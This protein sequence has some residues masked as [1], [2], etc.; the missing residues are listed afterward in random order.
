MTAGRK[1]G[2]DKEKALKAAMLVFWEKGYAGASLADLT[3]SM[4]INKPSLYA[5]FGNKEQLHRRALELYSEHYGRPNLSILLDDSLPVRGRLE[6]FLESVA[7]TQFDQDLPGGCLVSSC[8]SETASGTLP[9]DTVDEVK[10]MRVMT[11]NT[12]IECFDKA[13][14]SGELNKDFD[15]KI[16]AVLIGLMIHGSAVMARSGKPLEEVRAAFALSLAGMDL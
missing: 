3:T 13:K 10:S 6:I 8:V 4:G 1:R 7:R 5:A 14:A 12:L 2:F 16:N 9:A 15:S 11:E